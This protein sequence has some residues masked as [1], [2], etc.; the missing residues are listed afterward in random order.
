MLALPHMLSFIYCMFVEIDGAIRRV[1]LENPISA[2]KSKHCKMSA[3][4]R[5]IAD[6]FANQMTLP[7]IDKL[8]LDPRRHS[9]NMYKL[10]T[11]QTHNVRHMKMQLV[12]IKNC[13]F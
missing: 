13:N 8:K 12:C 9:Y 2:I 3:Q 4:K 5:T 6:S 7:E 1:V 10:Q 11:V